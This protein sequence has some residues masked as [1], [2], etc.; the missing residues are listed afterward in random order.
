M[1]EYAKNSQLIKEEMSV[2]NANRPLN[3]SDINSE[4]LREVTSS[5][6]SPE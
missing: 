1:K 4:K 3:I 6:E 2:C 5:A